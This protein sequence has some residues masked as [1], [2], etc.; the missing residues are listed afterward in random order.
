MSSAGRRLCATRR[1]SRTSTSIQS[2]SEERLSVIIKDLHVWLCLGEPM[3][4][5]GILE[6]P[7]GWRWCRSQ[8]AH[9]ARA[10]AARG[11]G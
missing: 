2:A 11:A 6:H 5:L 9:G 7:P 1:G 8:P 3:E 4:L 10:A